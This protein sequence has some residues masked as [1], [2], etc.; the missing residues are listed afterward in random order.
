MSATTTDPPVVLEQ[1]SQDF[2]E[3]TAKPPFLPRASPS[4]L[5]ATTASRTTS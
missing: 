3:A 1:A 4:R 5:S 2:V